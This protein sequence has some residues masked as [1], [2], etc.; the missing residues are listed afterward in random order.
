[1]TI[2]PANIALNTT[3]TEHISPYDINGSIIYIIVVVIWYA[4]GFGLILIDDINPQPGRVESR[5]YV[6]VYQ[7]VNDL[8]EQQARND[9]LIELKDQNRRTKLWQIY[10]G[11]QKSHPATIQKDEEAI[12]LIA[13]QLNDLKEQR[14]LLRNAFNEGS[15]D[16]PDDDY[17]YA[18][19]DSSSHHSVSTIRKSKSTEHMKLYFK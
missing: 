7:T 11:T 12:E 10:Y 15:L 18:N 6:S 8:H 13:K 2:S 4:I 19:S 9:I 5:K 17:N 14:R 3:H 16:R 1:M